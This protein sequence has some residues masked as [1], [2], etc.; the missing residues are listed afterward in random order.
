MVSHPDHIE[1]NPEPRCPFVPPRSLHS[2]V[3]LTITQRCSRNLR[4]HWDVETHDSMPTKI[5]FPARGH[6]GGAHSSG[7][8]IL[9][10]HGLFPAAQDLMI[11]LLLKVRRSSRSKLPRPGYLHDKI[12]AFLCQRC[13]SNAALLRFTHRSAS[14]SRTPCTLLQASKAPPQSGVVKLAYRV[15]GSTI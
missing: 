11:S 15:L 5:G 7:N 3:F 6:L 13:T 9:G 1:F 14:R 10:W 8:C 12:F 2:R 4:P